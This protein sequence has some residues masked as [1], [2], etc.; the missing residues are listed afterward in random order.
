MSEEPLTIPEEDAKVKITITEPEGDT[1]NLFVWD[2]DKLIAKIWL[3]PDGRITY[4]S[5][6][7]KTTN[8]IPLRKKKG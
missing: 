6:V 5:F 4:R 8:E 7:P 1:P 3:Y 2:E